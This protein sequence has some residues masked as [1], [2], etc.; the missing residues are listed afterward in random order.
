MTLTKEKLN[1]FNQV[2]V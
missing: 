2:S 1:E